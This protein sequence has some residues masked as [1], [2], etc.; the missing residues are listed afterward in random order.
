MKSVHRSILARALMTGVALLALVVMSAGGVRA[1]TV[2]GADGTAGAF[3]YGD[4]SI[5]EACDVNGGDGE[6][7]SA[8]GNPAVAI[9]GNGGAAGDT[10]YDYGY[11]DGDGTGNGGNGGSA[12]AVATGSSIVSAS[13][14]GVRGRIQRPFLWRERG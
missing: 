5:D 11:G 8:G 13:A 12:T 14:T 3:C 1:G 10:D 2:T 7:V 6:S 4:P 9:G